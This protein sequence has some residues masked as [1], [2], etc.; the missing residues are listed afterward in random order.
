MQYLRALFQYFNYIEYQLFIIHNLFVLCMENQN[1][2]EN[3]QPEE[4]TT[5]PSADN[6]NLFSQDPQTNSPDQIVQTCKS[7]NTQPTKNEPIKQIPLFLKFEEL[8]L[9]RRAALHLLPNIQDPEWNSD[10]KLSKYKS[11]RRYQISDDG[12]SCTLEGG[13]RLCR[14]TRFF[15]NEGE[16]YWE[17]EFTN[18]LTEDSHVR[19]G[20]C[21]IRA[22]MES[23]VGSDQFGYC[24]KDL[25]GVYHDGYKI[26]ST[27]PFKVGDTIGLGFDANGETASLCAWIN[28]K[29]LGEIANGIDKSYQW[30]PA[31]SIYKNAVV[32]AHFGPKFTYPNNRWKPTSQIP[33]VTPTEQYTVKQLGKWMKGTYNGPVPF[34][35]IQPIMDVALEPP[36]QLPI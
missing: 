8:G 11:S 12:L 25:G 15:P 3:L 2:A 22:D 13:Y 35:E 29:S 31:V 4:N 33:I 9:I 16:W 14:A 27:A 19:L 24:I 23:V 28:G 6:G 32:T 34:S 7:T 21:T 36:Q 30:Q 20:I 10:M 1:P 18:G 5:I 17:F 26:K